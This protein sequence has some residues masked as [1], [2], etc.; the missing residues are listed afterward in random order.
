[1]AAPTPPL[2]GL[3]LLLDGYFHQDFRAEHGTHEA[4]AR[5]FVAE[6]SPEELTEAKSS[7]DDFL[8]WAVSVKR[9]TWQDAL[10]RTGG[11]WQPRSLEP[12]REVLAILQSQPRIA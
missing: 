8:L 4:A 1:M 5:A 7:L 12:L 10:T 2:E 11:G 3:A 9:A 6:A